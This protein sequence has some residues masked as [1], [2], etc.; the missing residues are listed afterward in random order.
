VRILAEKRRQPM[1][2]ERQAKFW[3]VLRVL[4]TDYRDY[5]GSVERWEDPDQDYPD[6]S[7][8]CRWW[9]P[10][11]DEERDHY[12]YDWGVCTNP[13]SPRAGLLTW[14]HQAGHICFSHKDD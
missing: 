8:G 1:S 14:E 2:S 9:A 11:H 3:A 5:G 13:N 4:P 7:V 6:C 12:D 10:L